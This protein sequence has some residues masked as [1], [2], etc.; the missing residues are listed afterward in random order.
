MAQVSTVTR[1]FSLFALCIVTLIGSACTGSQQ[2]TLEQAKADGRIKIG[3]ANEIPYAY[4]DTETGELTGEAPSIAKHILSQM[5]INQVEGVLVEFGAL[6]PGLKAGR[7]DMIAAGM[8]VTPERC[9][10]ILFSEPTYCIGEAFLVLAGNPL[11]L[12]SYEDVKANPEARLGLVAGTVEVGYANKLG[13]PKEQQVKFPD[14]TSAAE[15]VRSGR[16]D[17]FAGTSLTINELLSRLD[18]DELE[19]ADPFEDP[20]IDG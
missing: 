12:N 7:F 14:M 13:I 2:S 19:K 3:F 16:A 1:N 17:A 18:S 11:N 15:G 6:I 20:V 10:Q 5:D 4:K 9:E 8:Y